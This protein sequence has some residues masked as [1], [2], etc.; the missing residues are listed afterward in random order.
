MKFNLLS[1]SHPRCVPLR[2]HLC[3]IVAACTTTRGTDS[4]GV[5]GTLS[6]AGVWLR[7]TSPCNFSDAWCWL[8]WYT[9]K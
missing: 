4:A 6:I 3:I 2:S 7:S 1:K 5:N 9:P 8:L